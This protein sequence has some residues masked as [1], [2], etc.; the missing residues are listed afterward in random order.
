MNTA[1]LTGSS[2][3]MW[4]IGLVYQ[5]W[6]AGTI[7]AAG[8]GLF[9]LVMS[10]GL[11]ASTLAV[12]GIR[13]A[14]T[15]LISEQVGAGS[16]KSISGAVGKCLAYSLF[17]GL[18]S[19]AVLFLIA[20]PVG[21]LWIG[22]ARTVLSLKI[23]A[24]S[25]PFISLAAVIAGYF[26]ATGRVYKTALSQI[27]EQ[28]IRISLVIFLLNRVPEGD[29]A[30]SCA[31]VVAGGVVSDVLYFLL[32]L[33]FYLRDRKRHGLTGE[34]H[35]GV[36][37]RMLKIALPLAFSAYARTSLSTL[38]Q[39]LVPRGFRASGMSA[40]G[41]L[42]GYGVIQ[43][44]VFPIIFFP[45]CFLMS[46]AEL[47]VPELTEAQVKGRNLYIARTTSSLM[48]RCMMF[49]VGVAALM[50]VF[51]DDLGISIYKSEQVGEYV[52]FFSLLIPVM[53]M[54]MVTD[55]CLKGLGQMMYSMA[56]NIAEALVGVVLVYYL[57][58]VYGLRGYL[59]IIFFM[60]CFNFALSFGRLYVITS[61]SIR[62]VLPVLPTLLAI[63]SAYGAREL[64]TLT[65]DRFLPAGAALAIAMALAA[66]IYFLLLHLLGELQ[67]T[68][69]L[70]R[71]V[72]QGRT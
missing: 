11:L 68:P 62:A 13:F 6:L 69:A 72:R 26:T 12:S 67:Y 18:S 19:C 48:R 70:K 32:L 31:A 50:Y 38:R 53:Y 5:V 35:P 66:G 63:F 22:D 28:L 58:P 59:G 56:Y 21:F 47:L 37:V 7:G 64:I 60:E 10:V 71:P 44:M 57:L 40:D 20:E 36:T 17:F 52:R 30:L 23:L 24:F 29:I 45:S 55:G 1:L 61:L 49:S 9:Q 43:G 46:L 51:S 41:A 8:I 42:A 34:H 25:M 15:R 27:S 16:P 14:T 39:M 54:D 4:C 2:L 3:V 65:L 33:Q